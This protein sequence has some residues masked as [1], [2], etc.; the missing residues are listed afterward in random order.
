MKP[1]HS[2]KS[3]VSVFFSAVCLVLILAFVSASG[4]LLFGMYRSQQGAPFSVGGVQLYL[5]GTELS[6]EPVY[7]NSLIA[8]ASQ[9]AYSAKEQVF[10]TITRD[11]QT[12]YGIFE[13]IS[14][15]GTTLTL[16]DDSGEQFS[17]ALDAVSGKIIFSSRTLGG[18]LIFLGDPS[19]RFISLG[20]CA[21]GFILLFLL[22]FLF[23]KLVHRKSPETVS[24]EEPLELPKK[25]K[26]DSQPEPLYHITKKSSDSNPKKTVSS[27]LFL[28]DD[29]GGRPK[30]LVEEPI[31]KAPAVSKTSS[32]SAGVSRTPKTKAAAPSKPAASSPAVPNPAKQKKTAE[33][34]SSNSSYADQI[35][36]QIMEEDHIDLNQVTI[37]MTEQE[38]DELKEQV[39]KS[40]SSPPQ[41]S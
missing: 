18:L 12:Q 32:P 21:G 37:T 16:S 10:V 36:Q 29:K 2:L 9:S 8:V 4:L 33:A 7:Q 40:L 41:N 26:R 28:Y 6:E 14:N 25:A 30:P 19:H 35:V 22:I 38:L 39:L 20:V 17:S 1:L 31:H 13:V 23:A 15:N 34:F 24:T 5:T 11:E 27:P 3:I